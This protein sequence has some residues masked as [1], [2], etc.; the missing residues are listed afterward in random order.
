MRIPRYHPDKNTN[1]PEA[2]EQFEEVAFLYGILSD[3]EKRRQYDNAGFGVIS[4]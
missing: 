2:A 1:N 4:S 3:P